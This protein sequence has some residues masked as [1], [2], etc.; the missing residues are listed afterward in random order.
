MAV[1]VVI[2]NM[3]SVRMIHIY[4]QIELLHPTKFD[5]SDLQLM[6]KKEAELVHLTHSA[7]L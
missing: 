6:I 5:S 7:Y 4:M 3:H 2:I 1:H